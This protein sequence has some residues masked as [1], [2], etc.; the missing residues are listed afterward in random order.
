M[1]TLS[2]LEALYPALHVTICGDHALFMT[3]WSP[4]SSL[5]WPGLRLRDTSCGHWPPMAQGGKQQSSERNVNW[6][7][8]SILI[9]LSSH[10]SIL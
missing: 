5:H 9:I 3:L 4:L 7:H 10:W 2:L 6:S 8:W 1:L